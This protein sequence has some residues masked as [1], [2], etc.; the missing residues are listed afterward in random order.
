MFVFGD[1]TKKASRRRFCDWS[2]Y[3]SPRSWV[4]IHSRE[5]GHLHLRCVR[6]QERL[7]I[8]STRGEMRWQWLAHVF[9]IFTFWM[10]PSWM[11]MICFCI[12]SYDESIMNLLWKSASQLGKSAASLLSGETTRP[13]LDPT[14][15]SLGVSSYRWP[16]INVGHI[17][18]WILFGISV[19]KI[20]QL[21][22]QLDD[23]S[24]LKK[25]T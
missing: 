16:W 6:S 3:I 1:V 7:A 11:W 14:A 23:Y 5:F 8:T 25:K 21:S 17:W 10:Y 13:E 19:K 9:S 15:G 24:I 4:H 12:I 20:E 22:A 18:I 2:A